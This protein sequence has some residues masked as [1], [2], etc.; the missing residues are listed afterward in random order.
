MVAASN[1][2]SNCDGW[3]DGTN[4]PQYS[5]FDHREDEDEDI[6]KE[7]DKDKVKLATIFLFWSCWIF[8]SSWNLPQ[9]SYLN[10]PQYSYFDHGEYED[11]EDKDKVNPLK[12]G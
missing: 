4:L 10:L 6:V 1:F 3:K 2:G 7:K 12:Y 8:W 9:Y 5:Y 11:E